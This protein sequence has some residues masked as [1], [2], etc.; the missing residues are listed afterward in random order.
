MSMFEEPCM[1]SVAL[2]MVPLRK[3]V[4][5]DLQGQAP[6]VEEPQLW[7]PCSVKPCSSLPGGLADG[8][9]QDLQACGPVPFSGLGRDSCHS[10]ALRNAEA[11]I[12]RRLC[13]LAHAALHP[14][15]CSM[16]TPKHISGALRLGP[17]DGQ[18]I[19]GS[20]MLNSICP[21]ADRLDIPSSCILCHRHSHPEL[22]ISR[23]PTLKPRTLMLPLLKVEASVKL[24]AENP[25]A[26]DTSVRGLLTIRRSKAS[27]GRNTCRAVGS[28][29]ALPRKS[30]AG[31]D[32]CLALQRYHWAGQ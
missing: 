29:G 10:P 28:V 17:T 6:E 3:A 16:T 13:R 4:R 25:G 22:W 21:A 9:S 19:Y 7:L 20:L 12:S 1:L 26:T 30:F 2:P 11:R 24:G 27:L 23:L 32:N 18:D 15:H 14:R 8:A 5:L 31:R